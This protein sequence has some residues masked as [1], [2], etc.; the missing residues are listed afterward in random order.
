MAITTVVAALCLKPQLPPRQEYWSPFELDWFVTSSNSKVGTGR[1][2]SV[3]EMDFAAAAAVPFAANTEVRSL[4]ARRARST[5]RG[6]R[7]RPAA[8][9]QLQPLPSA[10]ADRPCSAHR[11]ALP[12]H[13][14]GAL[15]TPPTEDEGR[16]NTLR[17][18]RHG[19]RAKAETALALQ[20]GKGGSGPQRRDPLSRPPR[21]PGGAQPRPGPSGQHLLRG[22]PHPWGTF[23]PYR[24][25]GDSRRSVC[26]LGGGGRVPKGC[27]DTGR[28]PPSLPS[29]PSPCCCAPSRSFR[30]AVRRAKRSGRRRALS[31]PRRRPSPAPGTRRRRRCLA[32]RGRAGAAQRRAA[33]RA[34]PRQK[35]GEG[36][37]RD[38]AWGCPVPR[39]QQQ[40]GDTASSATASSRAEAGAGQ[41]AG[42][43]WAG[44]G[45]AGWKGREMWGAPPPPRH[46]SC[47]V[48]PPASRKVPHL[49]GMTV[50][51]ILAIGRAACSQGQ[52]WF[53]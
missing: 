34:G 13:P 53:E 39:L 20:A 31:V 36:R 50:A 9:R 18:R 1:S 28:H 32:F 38:P 35:A 47:Q 8:S 21:P 17:H 26:V 15:R 4:M 40:G 3:S 43:S 22:T 6:P 48:I 5:P 30:D 23:P 45:P 29:S 37:E 25:G 44:Y 27:R 14:P 11:K 41:A 52:A 42:G 12:E 2:Y 24:D 51:A 19:P 33:A 10:W 7:Y 49:T 46:L 16:A